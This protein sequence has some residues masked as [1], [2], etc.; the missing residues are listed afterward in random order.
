MSRVA[1]VTGIYR[2]DEGLDT[3][4]NILQYGFES[5]C[6]DRVI[7]ATWETEREN[8][9]PF[10]K[11][12]PNVTFITATEPAMRLAVA[13]NPIVQSVVWQRAA[14]H[15]SDE[16]V[17]LKLRTDRV[18]IAAGR[19]LMQIMSRWE[20]VPEPDLAGGWPAL[21]EQRIIS[22]YFNPFYAF[23]I[24]DI[25]F[26]ASAK[27][28]KK[29]ASMDLGHLLLHRPPSTEGHFHSAPFLQGI[30]QALGLLKID[31]R[32]LSGPGNLRR[33]HEMQRANK[34]WLFHW[35]SYLQIVRRY[36]LIALDPKSV[37]VDDN[38][39]EQLKRAPQKSLFDFLT[40]ESVELGLK[41]HQKFDGTV[42]TA[43]WWLD[44]LANCFA[45]DPLAREIWEDLNTS[46]SESCAKWQSS[47]AEILSV[48]SQFRSFVESVQ[49]PCLAALLPPTKVTT[50]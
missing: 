4:G 49:E 3:V 12:F 17:V 37:W 29:M 14:E 33:W 19:G 45:N 35:L 43:S 30:P 50:W 5:G 23:L 24:H 34:T 27:D 28:F 21:L 15:M 41:N 7:F 38:R 48:R 36:Y 16:D 47:E 39:I 10:A 31:I 22:P 1:L 2:G 40:A 46:F 32:L 26:L 18:P 42:A 6:L 44:C 25:F 8:L 11:K 13:R 9:L 20:S